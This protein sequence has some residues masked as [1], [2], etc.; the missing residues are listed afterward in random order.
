[1]RHVQANAGLEAVHRA[2][3]GLIFNDF[4]SGPTAADNN[5]LHLAS[6]PWVDKMLEHA[7]PAVTPSVRKIFFSTFDEAIVWLEHHR[8]P[9]GTGWKPCATCS[10]G[11][12]HAA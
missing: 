5:R 8:G 9:A 11:G 1:M 2:G 3:G 6:C 12:Q 4:T 7:D 10:P